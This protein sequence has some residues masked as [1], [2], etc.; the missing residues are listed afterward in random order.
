MDELFRTLLQKMGARERLFDD[1][2]TL[3]TFLCFKSWTALLHFMLVGLEQ[4]HRAD[5]IERWLVK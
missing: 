3:T 2:N 1:I 5:E 4:L